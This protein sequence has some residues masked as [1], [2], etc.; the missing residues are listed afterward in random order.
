MDAHEGSYPYIESGL[1]N[2]TLMNIPIYKCPDC[3]NSAVEIPKMNELHL[4]IGGLLVLQPTPLYG[5]QACYLRKSL[6]YSQEELAEKI[7]VT[8]VTVARWE[9]E[10]KPMKR[11]HDK[12]LRGFYVGKKLKDLRPEIMRT[13]AENVPFSPQ[14]QSLR[15][16]KEDWAQ[17]DFQTA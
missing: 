1:K 12:H 6:G 5:D 11:D 2:V 9:I 4:L 10:T 14:K 16:R 15:I 8:R 3:K 17:H 13:L 7:G